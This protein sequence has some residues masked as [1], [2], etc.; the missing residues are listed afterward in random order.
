[1]FADIRKRVSRSKQ[2]IKAQAK[3][4]NY[5]NGSDQTD[6][7]IPRK[8]EEERLREEFPSLQDAWEQYQIVL[9]MVKASK[10]VEEVEADAKAS[11][12][13]D[14]IRKRKANSIAVT[15]AQQRLKE[16]AKKFSK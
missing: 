7:Y 2:D 12:I 14:Q 8:S 11:D 9:K 6:I 16:I 5:A 1:M 10:P 3:S 15:P 13:L 4:W